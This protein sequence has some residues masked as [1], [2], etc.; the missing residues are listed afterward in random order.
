MITDL[1]AQFDVAKLDEFS[2]GDPDGAHDRLIKEQLC[3]CRIR[4][5]LEF[6]RDRKGIL[7]GDKGTGKTCVFELLKEG[8]LRFKITPETHMKSSL[9]MS[10][11]T[12]KG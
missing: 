11:S 12:T 9:S 5:L 4:P 2:F 1:P 8:T 3:V 6:L 10:S 7:V